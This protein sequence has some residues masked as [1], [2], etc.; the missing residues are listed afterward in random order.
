MRSID[1]LP[2]TENLKI[3]MLEK[4]YDLNEKYN[5]STFKGKL[6]S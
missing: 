4:L 6:L 5:Q 2:K 3:E 1:E